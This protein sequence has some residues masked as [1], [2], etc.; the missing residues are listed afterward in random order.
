ML[1]LSKHLAQRL[2]IFEINF[3]LLA[4]IIF[5]SLSM[6]L[7]GIHPAQIPDRRFDGF[8][9]EKIFRKISCR[10]RRLFQ[11][12]RAE[13][14]MQGRRIDVET[15][16]HGVRDLI[17]VLAAGPWARIGKIFTSWSMMVK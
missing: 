5:A 13:I 15:Q 8:P 11:D 2:L 10:R 16:M 1:P 12:S 17:D 3:E 6:G 7:Q 14:L 9:G 4:M